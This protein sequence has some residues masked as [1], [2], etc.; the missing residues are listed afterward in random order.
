MKCLLQA[1]VIL[2][3]LL[4]VTNGQSSDLGGTTAASKV[5]LLADILMHCSDSRVQHSVSESSSS[6]GQV[7]LHFSGGQ[8]HSRWH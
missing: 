6:Q 4:S 1:L 7:P 8:V 5:G 3:A 2:L